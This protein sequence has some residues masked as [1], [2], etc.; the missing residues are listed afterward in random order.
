MNATSVNKAATATKVTGSFA[1]T[2]NSSVD[3]TRVNANAPSNVSLLVRTAC[4]SGRPHP[5][6]QVV[7]YS[8]LRATN[9][10]TLVARRAGT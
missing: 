1:V 9:G 10:S 8:S 6:T 3:I 7:H 4:L 5:L 2:P